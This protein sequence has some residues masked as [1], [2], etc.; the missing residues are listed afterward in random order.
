VSSV[1]NVD[2][3]TVV[4]CS[5]GRTERGGVGLIRGGYPARFK[6]PMSESVGAMSK[7]HFHC[8]DGRDFVLDREGTEEVV[9]T[10]LLWLASQTAAG[11]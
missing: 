7:H 2:K 10:N 4:N 3:L 11:S 8:T 9:E 5:A 6:R 1:E